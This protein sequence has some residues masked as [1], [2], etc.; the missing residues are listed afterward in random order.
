MHS[1]E[2][3]DPLAGID[4]NK[5]TSGETSHEVSIPIGDH[6]LFVMPAV[7]LHIL[8]IGESFAAQKVFRDIQG[9]EAN[10][11]VSDDSDP[12]SFRGKLCGEKLGKIS[13]S[14]RRARYAE[15]LK[16]TA[17]IYHDFSFICTPFRGRKLAETVGGAMCAIAVNQG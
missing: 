1:C 15:P 16:K 13:H 17:P 11:G 3:D 10:R 4:G 7:T 14:A 9:S 12:L 5:M 6:L 8:H 2:N